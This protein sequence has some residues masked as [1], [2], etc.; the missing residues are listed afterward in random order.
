L[1]TLAQLSARAT[2]EGTFIGTYTRASIHRKHSLDLCV[3][4]GDYVYADQF[5]DSARCCSTGISRCLNCTDITAHKYGYVPRT[6]VLFAE[7]LHVRGFDHRVG[8][9]NCAHESLGLDH[10]ECF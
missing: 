9:F 10:S 1:I 4:S 3:G 6:D 7:Q 8:S 5:T 2:L